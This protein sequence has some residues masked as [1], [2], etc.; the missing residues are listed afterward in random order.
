MKIRSL[1]SFLLEYGEYS[2]KKEKENKGKNKP[3][4]Q[5]LA[6]CVDWTEPDHVNPSDY[7]YQGLQY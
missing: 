2:T 6:S 5:F 4:T 1:F 7:A 3:P